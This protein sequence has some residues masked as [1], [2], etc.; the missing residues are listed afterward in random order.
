MIVEYAKEIIQKRSPELPKNLF[1]ML[2]SSCG[3]QEVRSFVISRIEQWLHNPKCSKQAQE[4]LMYLCVNAK[5]YKSPGAE[6]GQ[7]IVQ[8]CKLRMKTKQ[9]T[10]LFSIAMR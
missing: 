3:L 5:S 10:Q 2:S 7:Y 4:L 8:I 6:G 9:L 1:R